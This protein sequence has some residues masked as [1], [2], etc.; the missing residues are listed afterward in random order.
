VNATVDT[1]SEDALWMRANRLY[2]EYAEL[3]DERQLTAWVDLFAPDCLYRA[4]SRENHGAGLPL[5]LMR[6]EGQA[7]LRDRVKAI[8]EVS[9]YAARSMR[10]I[11]SGVRVAPGSEPGTFRLRA[12]F[13]VVQS[14]EA[15]STT[16][17]AAGGYYDEVRLLGGRWVFTDKTSVYDGSL[18]VNSMVYPL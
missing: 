10:H 1:T 7:G 14:L 11:I 17:Y 16:V 12:S 9:V 5:S 6:C 8:E 2:T 18:I 13:V 15:A 4:I 3:L